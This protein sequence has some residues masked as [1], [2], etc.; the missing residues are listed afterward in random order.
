M[1]DELAA[2]DI[3]VGTKTY[4]TTKA[5]LVIPYVTG[6]LSSVI[7]EAKPAVREA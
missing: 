5:V 7:T 6:K 4:K 1:P 3:K 2:A